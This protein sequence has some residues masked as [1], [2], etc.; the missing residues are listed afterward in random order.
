MIKKLTAA[1]MALVFAVSFAACSNG[2]REEITVGTNTTAY[3]FVDTTTTEPTTVSTTTTVPTTTT[4]EETTVTTVPF[5]PS[6]TREYNLDYLTQCAFVGDSVCMGLRVYGGFLSEREVFAQGSVGAR[7]IHTFTFTV[8]GEEIDIV[9]CIEQKQPQEVFLW[10]GLNDI[11]M[12]TKNMFADNLTKLADDVLSVSPDTKINIIG[13]TPT[14]TWHT[15]GANDRIADYNENTRL[16]CEEKGYTYID[17]WQAVAPDLEALPDECQSGDGLHLSP[18][19]YQLVLG[20]ICEM[21]GV[22]D[23]EVTTT[24]APDIT[25]SPDDEENGVTS[26]YTPSGSTDFDAADF[27]DCAFVG[28]SVCSGLSYYAGLLDPS[29]VFAATNSTA[30]NI[31]SFTFSTPEGELDIINC[32]KN[33]QPKEI[34]LWM[35]I[36]EIKSVTPSIFFMGFDELAQKLL[37]VSPDSKINIVGMTPTTTWHTWGA[38]DTIKQYNDYVKEMCDAKGYTFI[39]AWYAVA[40]E[41]KALSDEC[42][43]GDGLHLKPLAYKMLLSYITDVKGFDDVQS[44]TQTPDTPDDDTTVIF[45]DVTTSEDSVE[46]I[47]PA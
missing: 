6:G 40:G 3:S 17:A 24:A 33:K 29:S 41:N 10:M 19:A 4:T 16:L 20:Y 26:E 38:N 42:Q 32:I 44:D 1:V 27:A 23:V 43:S 5:V 8:D 34:F 9:S 45:P 46:I 7:N 18:L 11:N 21:K 37:E 30:R 14:T 25:A 12:T 15:W 47:I 28:D 36:N 39:D 13:M 22:I 2:G 35:G 31:Y